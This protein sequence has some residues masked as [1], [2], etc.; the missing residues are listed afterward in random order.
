MLLCMHDDVIVR[1]PKSDIYAFETTADFVFES[2]KGTTIAV[3][4]NEHV[5][6]CIAHLKQLRIGLAE[7]HSL[8]C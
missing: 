4:D 8:P 6:H 1:I 7:V 3:E 2:L 5:C